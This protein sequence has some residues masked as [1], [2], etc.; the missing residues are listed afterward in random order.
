MDAR[1]T[2]KKQGTETRR[3][4]KMVSLRLLPEEHMH[5]E[6]LAR[7]RG[8]HIASLFEAQLTDLL[9]EPLPAAALTA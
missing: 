7:A 3:R 8:V 5:L 2:P 4:T 9:E 6:R 1:R